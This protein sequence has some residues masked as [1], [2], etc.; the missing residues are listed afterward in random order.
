MG[1]RS[2]ED[3]ERWR[4]WKPAK[5]FLKQAAPFEGKSEAKRPRKNIMAIKARE[6]C[7]PNTG[8]NQSAHQGKRA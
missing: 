4:E 6:E 5:S 7:Q 2:A 1:C 8:G 3:D